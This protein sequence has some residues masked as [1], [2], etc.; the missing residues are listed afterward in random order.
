[1]ENGLR[2][3]DGV[4]D[5]E[6]DLQANLCTITP[7][8]DRLPDLRGVVAAVRDSGY[9]PGRLWIRARGATATRDG[10]TWFTVANSALTL[11]VD[12]AAG[13]DMLAGEVLAEREPMTVRPG[14]IPR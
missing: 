9:R 5:V 14:P 2:L 10:V 1:V 3:L 7:Q 4:A 6:V 11:R 8:P 13:D 12:G